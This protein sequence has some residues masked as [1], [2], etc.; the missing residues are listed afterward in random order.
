MALILDDADLPGV[1]IRG[2][3]VAQEDLVELGKGLLAD[4]AAQQTTCSGDHG[5]TP[6]PYSCAA[7]S[8]SR[9]TSRTIRL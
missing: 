4:Y 5:M 3:L 1:V 9:S 6:R 2:G 8:T 7:G